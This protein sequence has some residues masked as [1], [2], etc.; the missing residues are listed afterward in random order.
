M[1]D[2]ES[3]GFSR[4]AF[5]VELGRSASAPAWEAGRSCAWLAVPL[6]CS[7]SF[8]M[9]IS[10]CAL[11]LCA[12]A[13]ALQGEQAPCVLG[14]GASFGD[15]LMRGLP[16]QELAD[17]EDGPKL[18]TAVPLHERSLYRGLPVICILSHEENR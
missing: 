11:A 16:M 4:Q 12:A 14:S 18:S 15:L 6:C 3:L 8:A 17:G 2:H 13:R 7:P 1:P 5:C 9:H 10:G